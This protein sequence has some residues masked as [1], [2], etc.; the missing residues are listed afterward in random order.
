MSNTSPISVRIASGTR[1]PETSG[2]SNY[3]YS[4]QLV[5][6]LALQK[7]VSLLGQQI[8]WASMV[9]DKK[10]IVKQGSQFLAKSTQSIKGSRMESLISL[11]STP[12]KLWLS[13]NGRLIEKL[14][15]SRQF[16]SSKAIGLLAKGLGRSRRFVTDYQLD[17]LTKA[18][19]TKSHGHLPLKQ[20][21]SFLAEWRPKGYY[22]PK[23]ATRF[24]QQDSQARGDEFGRLPTRGAN[25]RTWP[26]DWPNSSLV[27]IKTLNELFPIDQSN[28]PPKSLAADFWLTSFNYFQYLG[29]DR[30]SRFGYGKTRSRG[31]L[32]FTSDLLRK[33]AK[34]AFKTASGLPFYLTALGLIGHGQVLRSSLAIENR[35]LSRSLQSSRL[36]VPKSTNRSMRVSATGGTGLVST[37][38]RC[39]ISHGHKSVMLNLFLRIPAKLPDRQAANPMHQVFISADLQG[40]LNSPLQ[41]RKKRSYASVRWKGF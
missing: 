1:H 8:S 31:S 37:S 14:S 5:A 26:V 22:S 32:A 36:S 34:Q 33:D 38:P 2:S 28:L 30:S 10:P 25:E 18:T 24:A 39:F 27:T 35:N 12:G 29:P 4:S 15:T 40:P 17:R 3:F 11:K 6:N 13:A 21:S 16:F 19:Q 41:K 23:G 7:A 9:S 20:Q